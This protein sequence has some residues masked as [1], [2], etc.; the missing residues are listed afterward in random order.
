LI[1]NLDEMREI[2]SEISD[3]SQEALNDAA[4]VPTAAMK[5]E[6]TCSGRGVMKIKAKKRVAKKTARKVTA[7]STLPPMPA[8]TLVLRT[9]T[10]DMLG[11]T[12][13]GHSFTWPRQGPVECPDWDPAPKCGNG[14]HGLP[15]GQGDWSLLS[16][17][18][19]AVWQVV[20]VDTK[21]IVNIDGAKC[22]FPRGNV[23]FSGSRVDAIIRVLCGS[24]A[25]GAA[26]IAAQS[27][28]EKSGYSSTAVS[29]GYSSTAASSGNSSTA[30]SSGDS[31]TAAS[32]G[33][34]S[35]AASSGDCSTAASSGNC[36]T[37][38]SSGNSS[39]AASS[40]NWSTAASS[41]DY[42]K[43]ASSG[44]Y[45]KAASSGDCSTAASSGDSGIAATIGN[46]GM[47]KA[48]PLGLVIITYWCADEKRYRACVGNVGEEGILADTW[49]RVV[50]GK[51]VAA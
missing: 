33:D 18:D 9:C 34:Y 37:A 43:A 4:D 23:L 36:S 13:H 47:A 15:W 10:K 44:D 6:L 29:S 32:S 16:K 19:D 51:L 3:T 30:A 41:G 31:S 45:S 8:K 49:Y 39:K 42:S 17:A 38:A 46:G 35:K 27:W 24:E 48:G 20:E 25:M 40:G 21:E 7:K 1:E 14:L 26:Q 12:E 22:K 11:G 50:G 2:F 5:L 28:G